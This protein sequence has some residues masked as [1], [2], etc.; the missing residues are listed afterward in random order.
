[1]ANYNYQ[2]GMQASEGGGSGNYSYP[3]R[4]PEIKKEYPEV[5]M[6][7]AKPEIIET[8]RNNPAFIA[9]G[10]TG[11]G[12]T[13]RIPDFLL[14]AFPK[15]RI[16]V[17]QPRKFSTRSVSEYVAERRGVK[18]GTEVGFQVRYDAQVSRDTRLSFMTDGILLRKLQYD[19]LLKEFDVVMVDE[20]H[21][22]S[23]NIDFV[24]GLLKRVQKARKE[25]GL[26]ELK[27]I[28][29]SATIEKEKFVNFFG[30]FEGEEKVAAPSLEVSGR[31][32]PVEVEY[33][34]NWENEKDCEVTVGRG[35]NERR[36]ISIYK[37][38]VKR[39]KQAID[40]GPGD[41]LI[42]M[43]GEFE[44][45]K[46]MQEL[47]DADLNDVEIFPLY[48]SLDSEEQ[49]RIFASIPKRKIIVATNV[50][51]A[52]VT[53]DGV[54]FV[55]DSGLIKQKEFNSKTGIESLLTRHHA[56]SGCEQRKGR[57]GRTAPGTCYRLY[58]ENE[59]KNFEA[60]QEPEITRSNLDHVILTMKKMAIEDIRNFDFIDPPAPENFEQAFVTLKALGALD[61]N[62]DLTPLGEKMADLP[63]R[64]ELSRMIL[65]A[66]KFGCVESV[67]TI[68][69]MLEGK[70]FF[71][72]SDKWPQEKKDEAMAAHEVF[73]KSGSDFMALLEVWRGFE[74]NNFSRAWAKEN[75]LN[76]GLLDETYETVTELLGSLKKS[77]ISIKDTNQNES[78]EE[79]NEKI[80][81]SITAGLIQNLMERSGRFGYEYLDPKRKNGVKFFIH[82]QSATF[83]LGASFI[84]GSQ[85]VATTKVFARKCQEVKL[86]WL[87][88]IAPQLFE[89]GGSSTISYDSEKD[90]MVKETTYQ[91]KGRDE[92]ATRIQELA[93]GGV[94]EFARVLAEGYVYLS[95]MAENIEVY[96]EL[97][98]WETR[99]GGEVVAPNLFDWYRKNL[100][101]ANSLKKAE[102]I[103]EQLTLN[104]SD[105]CSKEKIA[106]IINKYPEEIEVLGKT[107]PVFYS[108]RPA[109]S[110]QSGRWLDPEEFKAVI[111]IFDWETLFSLQESDFPKIGDGKRPD[112][113]YKVSIG[114]GD[115]RS[116][117]SLEQLK[118]EIKR[119]KIE[120]EQG[121]EG[122]ES[123]FEDSYSP[124]RTG[125]F[126]KLFSGLKEKKSVTPPVE[127]KKPENKKLE[128]QAKPQEKEVMTT[129]IRE[130][131][132]LTLRTARELLSE[133]SAFPEPGLQG[134]RGGELKEVEKL[135]KARTRA[136]EA[137]SEIGRLERELPQIEEVQK[138]RS[139]VIELFKKAQK[140]TEE[141]ARLRGENENWPERYQ[142]Y[143][144]K[145][146]AMA[147]NESVTLSPERWE[148]AR[149]YLIAL[150]KRRG[151]IEDVDRELEMIFMECL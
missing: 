61:E 49:D 26:P 66:E 29:T 10:E 151:Q 114:H 93:E 78:E 48:G 89:S 138:G 73:K 147:V 91:L 11:S 7:K 56:K 22:R 51:E 59:Y 86:D 104:F 103:V 72:W 42:F 13:T 35:W 14:D 148:K 122:E 102:E 85:I 34:E 64:P 126:G 62:E 24:L 36:E 111:Q 4:S 17:T 8:V 99:S 2:S 107:F 83:G 140:I 132:V 28:V 117:R 55:I 124:T 79:R 45:N 21:E 37:M 88:D 98:E 53:I 74:A 100:G 80:E 60:F 127:Q 19:R 50:A 135:V 108:Y 30:H 20:A 12:K 82:P 32:Y 109:S 57:A 144:E 143:S 95:C 142:N 77:G 1:M 9:I 145:I 58:T 96:N 131:F 113:V 71:F 121:R 119:I 105:F 43:P 106:E 137:L 68:A 33:V 75:F 25:K 97:S 47:K 38:A 65:E 23:L 16:A 125:T 31:M 41:I 69:A 40:K 134:L 18:I 94:E 76:V 101:K 129:E 5:P 120:R 115:F 130:N 123:D 46:T 141:L 3:V 133:A 90:Q 6:D 146:R 15:A 70:S 118:N 139:K 39:V 44:I 52:S 116:A 27:I 136:K 128:I 110:E 112:I 92:K 150:A 84:I 149:P 54:K 63:L 87:P 67:C 81:K